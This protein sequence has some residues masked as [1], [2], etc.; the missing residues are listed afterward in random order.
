MNQ[1]RRIDRPEPGHWAIRLVKG[2]PEVGACI[3]WEHTTAEPGRPTNMMDRSPFLAAYINGEPVALQD[4]WTR[5]GRHIT[6]DEYRH[7]VTDRQWCATYAPHLPE[8][9]PRKPVDL[10]N[11]PPVMPPKAR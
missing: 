11:L 10:R 9:N 3:R 1:G 4:V 6:P 8:A 7:L 2:G 5:R